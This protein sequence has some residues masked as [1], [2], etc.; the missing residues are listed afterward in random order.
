METII[1]KP[2]VGIN[3]I[4]FGITRSDLREKMGRFKDFKKNIFSK[5]PTDDFGFCHVYY[6]ENQK[7]EAIEIFNE[8]NLSVGEHSLMPC[9]LD[10]A[11]EIMKALDKDVEIE[12]EYITSVKLSI[13]I[14]C[15][16]DEVVAVLLGKENYYA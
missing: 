13:G 16:E 3:D 7:V 8:V 12:A 9:T 6:D 11:C 10:K 4:E 2:L 5:E 1:G 14:T 15:E